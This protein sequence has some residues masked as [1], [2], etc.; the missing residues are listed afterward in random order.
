MSTTDGDG[1][2]TSSFSVSTVTTN[3]KGLLLPQHYHKML[4]KIVSMMKKSI[5]ILGC[6]LSRFTKSNRKHRSRSRQKYHHSCY[7]KS[8]SRSTQRFGKSSSPYM[9]ISMAVD[10]PP[11]I[12]HLMSLNRILKMNTRKTL[13]IMMLMKRSGGNHK[14]VGNLLTQNQKTAAEVSTCGE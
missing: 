14:D 11:L 5:A 3:T 2:I 10:H 12:L 13:N 4:L 9:V 8:R 7:R 6:A 1:T